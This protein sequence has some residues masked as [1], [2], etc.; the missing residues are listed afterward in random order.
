MRLDC[1][2]VYGFRGFRDLVRIKFGRG[3][4][5]ITGVSADGRLLTKDVLEREFSFGEIEWVI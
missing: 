5:V 3:F 4:T 2:E 1:I